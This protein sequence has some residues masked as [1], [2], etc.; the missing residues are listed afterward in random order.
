MKEIFV[1][2]RDGST[3]P[4]DIEKIHRVVQWA[5]EGVSGVSAGSVEAQAKVKFFNGMKTSDLHNSLVDAAHELVITEH[6]NYDIVAGRLASYDVRKK[7]YGQFE[8]PHI[9]DIVTKNICEGWYDSSLLDLYTKEEW[10]TINSFIKHERDFTIKIAGMK[11]W[12]QKYLV[13]NRFT[14]E[15]KESPQIAYILIAAILMKKYVADEGLDIVKDYYDD[16]SEGGETIPTPILAGVRTPT[17]QFSSCV[18]I[19]TGDSISSIT[20]T[21]DAMMKY[22]AQKAGLGVGVFNLRATGRPVKGGSATTTGPIPFTQFLQGS[23]LSAS[24]GGIR[25]GSVT[26][27]HNIWHRDVENLLVLKNN[28]G[29]EETRIRHSD[30]GFNINGYLW[31]LMNRGGDFF[32]FSPE[33]VPDLQEAFF[34]NQARFAEL[35]EK[36]SKSPKIKSRVKVRAEDIRDLLITERTGTSRIY[37]HNVDNAN[38]HSS[39]IPEEF[40]IRLSNLCTEIHLSSIPLQTFDDPNGLISLCTLTNIVWSKVKTKKDLER[41]CRLAVYALDA[42]LDYQD[43]PLQAARNSTKWFRSLGIGVNDFAHFLAKHNVRYGSKECLE[44]VDEYME[45]QAYYLIKHSIELAKKYGPCEKYKSTRYGQGIVPIDTRKK[46]VDELLEHVERYDW[47]GIREQLKTYGIRNATLMAIPPSETSSKLL[48]LTNGI[49]P[50][51]GLVVSK[52]STNIVAPNAEKYRNRYEFAWDV[53]VENYL[54][55]AAILQKHIDQGISSN[56]TYDPSKFEDGKIPG[57]LIFRHL[58]LA[59][60]WGIKALYYNNNV[61][62]TLD[63]D[64]VYEGESTEGDCES[65][66]L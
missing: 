64:G 6:N 53:D 7:V 59:Y 39:F 38:E 19:E 51:R 26:F 14:G 15:L 9:V 55:T 41:S 62:D 61:K 30:H 33:E 56:T 43:Y 8:V 1:T 66:K 16:L 37:I 17:R 13:K 58:L 48:N 12:V 46:D 18:V 35:Y 11:E 34:S 5:C 3:E 29:T 32:L 28:K 54:K 40:P 42:L 24:Q 65:C 52:D 25:K 45:A 4:L 60:K 63:N 44:L 21:A 23:V 57:K 20:A 36:Y 10:D 31:R 47:E 27:Y 50:I 49:E 2:K 22:A